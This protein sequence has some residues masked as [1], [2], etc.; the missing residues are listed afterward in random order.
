M[1]VFAVNFKKPLSGCVPDEINTWYQ[2]LSYPFH[3]GSQLRRFYRGE[4][5]VMASEFGKKKRDHLQNV[6]LTI[7]QWDF[8]EVPDWGATTH[9][10]VN[11][12]KYTYFISLD[13][14]SCKRTMADVLDYL[15]QCERVLVLKFGCDEQTCHSHQMQ[16]IFEC[17]NCCC[18]LAVPVHKSHG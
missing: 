12:L 1:L 13:L 5:V 10:I 9:L 8:Q 2:V 3:W 15:M 18:L 7:S 16:V 17:E 4:I 14:V 6:V 11:A